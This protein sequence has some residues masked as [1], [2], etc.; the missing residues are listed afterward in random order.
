M[1]ASPWL[2]TL[3]ETLHAVSLIS[4]LMLL[5]WDPCILV[6][7]LLFFFAQMDYSD[8]KHRPRR[9]CLLTE[10]NE[11]VEDLLDNPMLTLKRT[12][13]QMK[14]KRHFAFVVGHGIEPQ[15]N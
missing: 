1:Q 12:K 11:T 13:K 6:E 10:M 2:V 9:E 4:A 3:G 5:V 7:T 15:H 8:G 14:K